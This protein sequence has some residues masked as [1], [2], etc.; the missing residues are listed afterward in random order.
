MFPCAQRRLL[1]IK[2]ET[3]DTLKIPMLDEISTCIGKSKEEAK[4]RSIDLGMLLPSYEDRDLSIIDKESLLK[5]AFETDFED[6][7]TLSCVDNDTTS[8][9][10]PN[11]EA[12]IIRD[13]MSRIFLE[14]KNTSGIPTYAP[15][16][17]DG[18]SLESIP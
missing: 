12:V 15:V 11:E 13:D 17:K 1:Q 2:E 10:R 16:D 4:K 14:K 18:N 6:D 5:T 8:E 9:T 7:L 3:D